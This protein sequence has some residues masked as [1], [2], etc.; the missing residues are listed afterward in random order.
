MLNSNSIT[1][2][3][4][5]LAGFFQSLALRSRDNLPDTLNLLTLWF[6]Y[7]GYTDVNDAVIAGI[8]SAACAMWLDVVPQVREQPIGQVSTA[9]LIFSQIIARIQT[10]VP[11]IRSTLTRLLTEIGR[12]HPQCLVYALNVAAKSP[13]APRKAAATKILN[14]MCTHSRILVEQVCLYYFGLAVPDW[15]S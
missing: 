9:A 12:Q 14:H 1:K 8:K 3:L 13:S 11:L 10:P 7:G 4:C 2:L 6:K 15:F 5:C